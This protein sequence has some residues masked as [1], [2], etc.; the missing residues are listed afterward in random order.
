MEVETLVGT[1][2]IGTVLVAV[3]TH[4]LTRRQFLA[5]VN[6]K[7]AE[8]ETEIT[9]TIKQLLDM[10]QDEVKRQKEHRESCETKVAELQREIE[11]LKTKII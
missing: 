6:K 11:I 7:R 3:L 2:T 8:V 9:G 10:A 1:G 5:E 4:F